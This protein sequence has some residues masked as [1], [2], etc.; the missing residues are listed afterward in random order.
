MAQQVGAFG[1]FDAEGV[2][3]AGVVPVVEAG[4]PR[5]LGGAS[6]LDKF[7][8]VRGNKT[9]QSTYK[10]APWVYCVA[11]P[12]WPFSGFNPSMRKWFSGMVGLMSSERTLFAVSFTSMAASKNS[13]IWRVQQYA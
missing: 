10:T 1:A 9:A 6:G 5:V 7:D 13:H 12:G 2:E 3:D 4:M 11:C 8:T